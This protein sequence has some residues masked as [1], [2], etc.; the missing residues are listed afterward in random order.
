M[1]D[2]F[3]FDIGEINI[4]KNSADKLRESIFSI[5]QSKFI[6]TNPIQYELLLKDIKAKMIELSDKIAKK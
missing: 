3:N 4:N 5:A 2:S 6:G 1:K